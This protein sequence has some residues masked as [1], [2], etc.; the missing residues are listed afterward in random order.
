[1]GALDDFAAAIRAGAN[2]QFESRQFKRLLAVP[3]TLERARIYT[4]QVMHWIYNRRECWAAAA[5]YA[6]LDVKKLVWLHEQEMF[7]GDPEQRGFETHIE[8][9]QAREGGVLGLTPEDY[10]NAAMMD[11]TRTACYAWLHLCRQ[12]PWLKAVA[13]AA[14]QVAGNS[15]EWVAEGG[16][17][18]RWARKVELELGLPFAT[19]AHGDPVELAGIEAQYP[20]MAVAERHANTPAKLA[21][22][23]EGAQE[24]WAID[25]VWKG[26]LADM[27][28]AVPV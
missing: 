3:L 27:I 4:L 11:G 28:E 14:T 1:M 23:L 24:A 18:G 22:M 2:M 21:L 6:P 26:V 13:A 15:R 12:S 7:G 19:A 16:L 17:S 8:F 5:C 9:L 25:R 10:R 20:L